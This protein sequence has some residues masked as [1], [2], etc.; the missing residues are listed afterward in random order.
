MK[1]PAANRFLAATAAIGL[2]F[3]AA[4]A[5]AVSID[6]ALI[7]QQV[8]NAAGGTVKPSGDEAHWNNGEL[9]N[10][11]GTSFGGGQFLFDATLGYLYEKDG[12][13]VQATAIRRDANGNPI[14]DLT[15]AYL[16]GYSGGPG[17]IGA[18]LTSLDDCGATD[19]VA[20]SAW[21]EVTLTF[22]DLSNQLLTVTLDHTLH[23]DGDHKLVFS[24]DDTAELKLSVDGTEVA[25]SPFDLNGL[26]TQ[27]IGGGTAVKLALGYTGSS[28]T[29]DVLA[30]ELYISGLEVRPVP[31]PAAAWLFA[32]SLAGLGWIGRRRHRKAGAV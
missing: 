6:F 32:S 12:I 19:N 28:F 26:P 29:F 10:I 25:D 14:D 5:Q 27:S 30:N 11:L 3:F 21:E 7:A 22:Y 13:R 15:D 18:C 31:L 2:T 8:K 4:G 9:Q 17:G 20:S 16:D 24:N 1:K 23:T